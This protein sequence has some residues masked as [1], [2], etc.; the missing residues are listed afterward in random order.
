VPGLTRR[1]AVRLVVAVLAVLAPA[2]VRRF[3]FVRLLGYRLAP[4]AVIGRALVLV[5]ELEMGEHSLI[6]PL[7]VIRG[8]RRVELGEHAVIGVLN[9]VNGVQRAGSYPGLDRDPSLYLRRHAHITALHLL[10]CSDAIEIGEFS[11]LAGNL[12]QVLTHS[13][14]IGLAEQR[15]APVRTGPYTFVG[16]RCTILAGV[17]IAERAVIGA[18]S[19]V[20]KSLP[21]KRTLYAGNPAKAVREL[22]EDT[23]WFTRTTG[24]IS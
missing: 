19:V 22:P 20:I 23:G 4:T 9:W 1:P 17:D 15:T 16:T 8:C 10:D 11:L 3:L 5:D 2:R 6:G 13:V 12:T 21:H 24:F 14:D 7:N 18:G